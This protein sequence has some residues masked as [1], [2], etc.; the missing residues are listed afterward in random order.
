MRKIIFC[1][2][3]SLDGFFEGPNHDIE[4]HYA[5][6]EHEKHAVE[7]FEQADTLLF[8]R[9]TYELMAGYWPQAPADA[10]ADYMNGLPKVVFSKTLDQV[11]WNNAR[12]AKASVADEIASLKKQPG[13][14]M[15]LFG[16]ANLASTFINL[17]LIDEYQVLV[18]PILLGSGTPLFKDI[19][20]KHKLKLIR[21]RTRV[22][23]VVELYYQ[24]F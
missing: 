19:G 17:D 16:S 11:N 24:R 4:W 20:A 14:N 10:V 9:V 15:L 8:G 13:K 21:T 18:S 2:M 1:N 7:L 6:E 23:G 22:S 12:L 3:V 5:D